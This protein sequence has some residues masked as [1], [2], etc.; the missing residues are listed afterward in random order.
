M[1]SF[2]LPAE[3]RLFPGF[4]AW[5]VFLSALLAALL[6]TLGGWV[7]LFVFCL[8]AAFAAAVLRATLRGNV[9]LPLSDIGPIQ[10]TIANWDATDASARRM[11]NLAYGANVMV[12]MLL[13]FGDLAE[14]SQS[15]WNQAGLERATF[16]R[17]GMHLLF[18]AL[19]LGLLSL[20]F[21]FLDSG[22][23]I[24][25]DG[26]YHFTQVAP[27]LK[28]KKR[29]FREPRLLV[30]RIYSWDQIADYYW[31]DRGARHV[32][33]LRVHQPPITIPQLVSYELPA[34]FSDASRMQ[35]DALFRAH[36]LPRVENRGSSTASQLTPVQA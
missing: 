27:W 18:V 22:M 20:N 36:V 1:M 2:R 32:L 14:M 13:V 15:G 9:L 25:K 10:M 7:G 4:V 8:F 23:L 28:S 19:W 12:W 17:L 33:H 21:L 35:L 24:T 3:I 34:S 16:A 11:R 30:R 5:F 31:R 29:S 6:I 26:V